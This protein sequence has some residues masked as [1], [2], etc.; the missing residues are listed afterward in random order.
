MIMKKELV[1]RREF[2]KT[3]GTASAGL[4]VVPG[5]APLFLPGAPDTLL[6]DS[7]VS[8]KS[9]IGGYGNWAASLL[10]DPPKLSYRLDKWDDINVWREK[11]VSASKEYIAAPKI[12][13]NTK[14]T[15]TK[16]YSYDGLEIEEMEWQLPY[17][18][19]TKAVVLKPQ[20]VKEPLPAILALHDHGGNKYFGNRK[21]IRTSDEP[22][23]LIKEHQDH[24]YGGFA[25]A[26]QMAK[27]GY[28]VLVNDAFTFASRRVLYEDL[29]GSMNSD[30]RTD[31]DPES[32]E[33]IKVYNDWAGQHEHVMSK[34]LFSAGTTWPGVFLAEDQRAVDIL[35]ERGDVDPNRIGCCGLSGGG[36]RTVYLG[37]LDSRIKCA[38]SVGFMTTWKDLILQKSYTHT[39]MTY[40]PLLPQFLDFPE[41]LG[42]RV[43]LPTMVL[44]NNED[45]LFNL[46]EM[47]RAD[48]IMQQL[49]DKAGMADRYTGR[50]YPGRHK[51]DGEMQADAFDWF[52][53]WLKV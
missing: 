36:L 9:I 5:S 44:N 45:Q 26:N 23:P 52:D 1:N 30:Q 7:T 14:V 41:I 25:W 17:G 11:A 10:V 33:N 19:A 53:R 27:R 12:E 24:Y 39:W 37:G 42:L 13:G 47:K 40:T 34:S 20:G 28:V 50:F 16:K 15:I 48:N 51:F 8:G 49:F 22:H 21:I 38:I 6:P 32:S 3:A 4:V 43:P 29:S 18:R 46:P 31:V 35:V 2:I